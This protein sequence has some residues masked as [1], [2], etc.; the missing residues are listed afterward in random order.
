MPEEEG[1]W[2]QTEIL[3]ARCCWTQQW[4][5]LQPNAPPCPA[6]C[7]VGRRDRAAAAEG[8]SGSGQKGE[9]AVLFPQR[10]A[11]D[12]VLSG[13]RM[14]SC[15]VW[16]DAGAMVWLRKGKAVARSETSLGELRPSVCVHHLIP[17]D[18]G[19]HALLVGTVGGVYARRLEGV[20]SRLSARQTSGSAGGPAWICRWSW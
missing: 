12:T 3:T 20:G 18:G 6:F 9:E 16:S 4:P 13:A 2:K 15:V 10:L 7:R 11:V 1:S 19:Q 17:T 8:S 14:R 5:H